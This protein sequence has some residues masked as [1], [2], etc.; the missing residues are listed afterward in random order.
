MNFMQNLLG[1]K[2]VNIA[3]DDDSSLRSQRSTCYST[4][5]TLTKPE[6]VTHIRVLE[7]HEDSSSAVAAALENITSML[8]KS[9][10]ERLSSGECPTTESV[11]EIVCV[12]SGAGRLSTEQLRQD[13]HIFMHKV[14]SLT[15][16]SR[17][18]KSQNVNPVEISPR[19][20]QMSDETSQAPKKLSLSTSS[21][22]MQQSAR[23]CSTS[24]NTQQ[25]SMPAFKEEIPFN[26]DDVNCSPHVDDLRVSGDIL[27]IGFSDDSEESGNKSCLLMQ[28]C[29][30]LA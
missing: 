8:C 20:R 6:V 15:A 14:N 2:T 9:A 11:I 4:T 26:D 16:I 12:K 23:I 27:E 13:R 5:Y 10:A 3:I 7:P 18:I 19:K 22:R 29:V 28:V 1:T 21:Q 30:S 24:A 17:D 25:Y